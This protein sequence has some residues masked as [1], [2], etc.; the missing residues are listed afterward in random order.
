MNRRSTKILASLPHF[1]AVAEELHFGR[2]AERLGMS[3]PPLSR[4]I[5]NLERDLGTPLFRRSRQGTELTDAGIVMFK[6][7]AELVAEAEEAIAQVRRASQGFAGRL[8]I[9]FATSALYSVVPAIVREFSSEFP[10]VELSLQEMTTDTQIVQL[11]HGQIDV[12]ILRSPAEDRTLTSFVLLRERLVVVLPSDHGFARRKQLKLSDL[13]YENFVMYSRD[14]PRLRELI[15]RKCETEGFEAKVVQEATQIPTMI[16]FVGA[17]L[18]VALIPETSRQAVGPDV[19]TVRLGPD[20]IEVDLLIATSKNSKSVIVE[21][22]V[23]VAR[24]VA[25]S[26]GEQGPS[27]R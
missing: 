16:A 6:R 22:F 20:G 7:G 9:G 2:A 15:M 4:R 17:G 5:L 10:D 18:G 27:Y 14:V 19:R 3:Q 11:Q 21:A 12:G 26:L 25:E 13:Q 8:R 1:M 23:R 24:K